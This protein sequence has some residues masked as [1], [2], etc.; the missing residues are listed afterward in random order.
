ME[1]R[2]RLHI[3]GMTCQSC[4]NTITGFLRREPGVRKAKIR[5][6]EGGGVVVFDPERTSEE[7][8]LKNKVFESG[9]YRARVEAPS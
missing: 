5:F 2:I 4:A 9:I 8:I 6:K 1:K 7:S 3:E